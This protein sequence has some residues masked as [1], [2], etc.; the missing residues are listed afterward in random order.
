MGQTSISPFCAP[1]GK[2]WVG[3]T[4]KYT[5]TNTALRD[6]LT[7]KLHF[8]THLAGSMVVPGTHALRVESSES[9]SPSPWVCGHTYS[10]Q[11][12]ERWRKKTRQQ[13]PIILQWRSW[14][15]SRYICTHSKTFSPLSLSSLLPSFPPPPPPPPQEQFEFALTAVAEEV[16][17]ILKAL[18]QWRHHTPLPTFFSLAEDRFPLPTQ[19]WHLTL[20]FL[21]LAVFLPLLSLPPPHLYIY[22]ILMNVVPDIS[23]GSIFTNFASEYYCWSTICV[24]WAVSE[25][26]TRSDLILDQHSC[27]ESLC[28]YETWSSITVMLFLNRLF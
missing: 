22:C 14:F 10:R 1:Q 16:N 24:V 27:C 2:Q 26:I 6:S 4:N 8:K 21:L 23:P 17:A 12:Q 9:G 7:Q 3:F 18:P 25:S 15:L 28:R 13:L 11:G 5:H 20:P 19:D